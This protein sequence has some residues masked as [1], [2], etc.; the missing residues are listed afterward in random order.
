MTTVLELDEN[1]HFEHFME[2]GIVLLIRRPDG[3]AFSK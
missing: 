2:R 3:S 1:E